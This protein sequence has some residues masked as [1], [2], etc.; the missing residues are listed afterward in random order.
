MTN[1]ENCDAVFTFLDFSF[2]FYLLLALHTTHLSLTLF[3]CYSLLRRFLKFYYNL[4]TQHTKYF[5]FLLLAT[6]YFFLLN[7]WLKMMKNC[8]NMIC[9]LKKNWWHKLDKLI[10][11][12]DFTN[13][14]HFNVQ[15]ITTTYSQQ[16]NS[17]IYTSLTHKRHVLHANARTLLREG[18]T[19]KLLT[20][21]NT[22]FTFC[23]TRMHLEPCHHSHFH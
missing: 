6:S 19:A 7:Y 11:F 5:F 12:F 3:L 23:A 22:K 10:D 21:N 1:D 18:Q 20:V 17:T 14:T 16:H 2:L 15:N 13:T 9:W 4:S 8:D